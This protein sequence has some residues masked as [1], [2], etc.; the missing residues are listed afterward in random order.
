M[1]PII[2]GIW[3]ALMN[4]AGFFTC[5]VDKRRARK[6]KWR[7]PEKTI[8]IIAFIGGSLGVYFALLLLRH[9][10]RRLRFMIGIPIILFMQVCISVYI[11]LKG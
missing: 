3:F 2:I 5:V 9:K 1:L 4:I 10:T 6:R 8:F 11:L 7:I